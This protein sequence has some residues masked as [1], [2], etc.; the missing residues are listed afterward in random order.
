MKVI[1]TAGGNQIK[2]SKSEWE[3]IGKTAG[4]MKKAEDDMDFLSGKEP[5]LDEVIAAKDNKLHDDFLATGQLLKAY[6]EYIIKLNDMTD[7]IDDIAIQKKADELIREAMR[8]LPTDEKGTGFK[9]FENVIYNLDKLQNMW[10]S[11]SHNKQYE[12]VL[13]W[14]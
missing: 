9:E 14:D 2:M 12:P 3:T 6:G 1:K 8:V 10:W 5:T 4:W 13:E 11:E 7:D